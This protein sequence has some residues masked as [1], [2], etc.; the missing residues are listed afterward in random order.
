MSNTPSSRIEWIDFCRVWTA[1]FVVLRHV[2]RPYG[3]FNYIIDLFNYRSL[4][5]FFF[6]AAGYFTHKAAAGQWLDWKRTRTLLVPFLFWTAVASILLLQ[7]MMHWDQTLAGDFNW[8]RWS[9]I[10]REMGLLNWC[11]WDFDNVPLWFLRTLI[12]LALFSPLLQRI[13]SKV[14]LVLVLLSFACSDVFCARDAETAASHKSW[15]VGWLPFRLYESILALG[16][17]SLGLWIRRHADF[18]RFSAFVREYAWAPVLAALLLLPFVYLFGFYPP[19]Q[20]SALVLLG[21]SCTMGI[22]ALCERYMPRFTHAVVAL[23]PAS[24][25]I[26]VTH[27]IVLHALRLIMTGSYGGRFT[28]TQCLYMPFVILAICSGLFF[29]LRRFCPRFVRL[30]ALA[31]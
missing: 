4:I 10:P 21:V 30:F 5:F 26:Y 23:A 29:L 19:V 22:G 6:L 27:Y 3:S 28:E 18:A 12:L 17:Y 31:K 16:F 1:F 7:P 25:F 8:F 15:R 14:L 9:L 20:S 2:D 24:F 11:Y 13:P